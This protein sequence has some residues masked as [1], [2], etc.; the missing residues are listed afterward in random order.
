MI[1]TES[2]HTDTDSLQTGWDLHCN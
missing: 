1:Q 2:F